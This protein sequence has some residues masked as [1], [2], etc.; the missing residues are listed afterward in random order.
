MHRKS[1]SGAGPSLS[2]G[3]ACGP[4]HGLEAS[5]LLECADRALYC[6]KKAGKNTVRL[7]DAD[8]GT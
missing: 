5:R 4:E 3:V 8:V 6:A 7:Y 2:V 1:S